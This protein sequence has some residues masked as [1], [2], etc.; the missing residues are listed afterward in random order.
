MN[1]I[2]AVYAISGP[3]AENVLRKCST[4]MFH[5]EQLAWNNKMW[6]TL[7]IKCGKNVD[8]FCEAV[9]FVDNFWYNFSME[10]V[11]SGNQYIY[12]HYVT[13]YYYRGG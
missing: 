7:W 10:Y 6:I 1:K 9:T 11:T 2:Y 3:A 5:V 8:N 13:H 12:I 4:K